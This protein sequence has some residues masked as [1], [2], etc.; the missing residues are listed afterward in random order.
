MSVQI[1]TSQN[2]RL[3]YEP[4]SIGDRI[5]ANL[6]DYLIYLAWACLSAFLF[7]KMSSGGSLSVF[8]YILIIILP[9][10]FYPLLTEYFLNGQTIGK[11]VL[12][13]KVVRLDGGKPTL[14]AYLLRWVLNIVDFGLFSQLVGVLTIAINGKGQ[15]IG[16]IAADTTVIRMVQRVSLNQV[17][18]QQTPTDYRLKYPEVS[19]LND[20]DI[21]TIREVLRRKNENL[22]ESTA[23]RVKEVL[24]IAEIDDPDLFLRNVVNDY[25]FM[26]TKEA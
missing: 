19:R 23:E 15:R 6:I 2:V 24:E 1:N 8:F 20:L 11:R 18:Y 26:A 7:Q 14:G 22:I 16:D 17:V 4:A 13:I 5:L 10:M 3:S 25:A 21:E 12:N 9:I